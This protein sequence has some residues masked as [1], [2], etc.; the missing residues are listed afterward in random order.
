MTEYASL[1]GY[2]TVWVAGHPYG[3]HARLGAV[4]QLKPVF[5]LERI[6]LHRA[7]EHACGGSRPS[8]SRC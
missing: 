8:L 3:R 1:Y 5:V 4:D 6:Q 2:D 7:G